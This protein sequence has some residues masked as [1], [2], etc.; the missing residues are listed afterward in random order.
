MRYISLA[1][2]AHSSRIKIDV[3]QKQQLQ[4]ADV[5]RRG[6][7]CANGNSQLESRADVDI[8]LPHSIALVYSNLPIDN[9]S[10]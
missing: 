8:T 7:S 2:T 3:Q 6:R 5:N 1:H 10:A 4:A 9:A